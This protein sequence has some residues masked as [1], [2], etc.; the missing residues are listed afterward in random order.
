[1]DLQIVGCENYK[2]DLQL[3]CDDANVCAISHKYIKD[4]NDD[5]TD[6][7]PI[8][9][10]G[11]LKF[12]FSIPNTSIR[13]FVSN[14]KLFADIHE[15]KLS[16]FTL[17]VIVHDK[18][19]LNV[20]SSPNF[21]EAINIES[22]K[23]IKSI[24]LSHQM[25][26]I[27][28]A[29]HKKRSIIA[30]EMGVGKTL[31]A[32]AIIILTCQG[33]HQRFCI[34]CP[35]I[36]CDVWMSEC[37]R[38]TPSKSVLVIRSSKDSELDNLR[39]YNGVIVSYNCSIQKDVLKRLK[40]LKITTLILDESHYIKNKRS[41][42]TKAIFAI[43]NEIDYVLLLSGT[44]FSKPVEM[45]TQLHIMDDRLFLS[46][47]KY[48]TNDKTSYVGRYCMP[49][50]EKCKFGTV[51]NLNGNDRILE[52]RYIIS[53]FMIRR[54]KEHVLSGLP[55][56]MRYVINIDDNVKEQKNDS[57]INKFINTSNRKC[58]IMKR[59]LDPLI[60]LYQSRNQSIV[61]FGHHKAMIETI[62]KAIEKYTFFVIDGKTSSDNR[63]MYTNQFQSSESFEI[64]LLSIQAASTG[65]T[66]TKASVVIFAEILFGPDTVLQAED[67]CHRLGQKSPVDVIYIIL[68]QSTDTHNWA[69]IEKKFKISMELLP[70]NNEFNVRNNRNT[71]ELILTNFKRRKGCP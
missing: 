26:G 52:L 62:K 55:K 54:T 44:P 15:V 42:R 41:K 21:D 9:I 34:I 69:I 14:L 17:R 56:K 8:E 29:Y 10:N 53:L 32:I 57:Y 20:T 46:F 64:M 60:Q 25:D 3:S 45:F 70:N 1:M 58:N 48:N 27:R 61:I 33:A 23:S 36:L 24:L 11:L 43:S 13:K 39:E 22:F 35:S 16:H 66:L 65:I 28:F 7:Y 18:L 67:R 47:F 40:K 12:Q 50:I 71:S 6:N 49:K 2:Y 59:I 5:D 19:R 51:W 30:D 38:W 31:Q 63:K 68:R 37:V 4:I